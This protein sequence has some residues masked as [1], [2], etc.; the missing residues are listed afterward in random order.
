MLQH[1]RSKKCIRHGHHS[2]SDALLSDHLA[3]MEAVVSICSIRHRWVGGEGN[4]ARGEINPWQNQ[5]TENARFVATRKSFVVTSKSCV[6]IQ[7]SLATTCLASLAKT[8]L[9]NLTQT[10]TNLAKTWWWWWE[11]MGL[12]WKFL[13]L[14][15]ETSRQQDLAMRWSMDELARWVN[16]A[17]GALTHAGFMLKETPQN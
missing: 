11:T 9:V 7:D 6:A 17:V 1:W 3:D 5:L 14:S 4:V 2:Q 16:A 13:A 15:R 12:N 8:C 10:F